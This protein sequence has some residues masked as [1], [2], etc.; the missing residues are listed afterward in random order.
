[1]KMRK[2]NTFLKWVC[3]G[4][5]W[6]L[7]VSVWAA[8]WKTETLNFLNF[9]R[10]APLEAAVTMGLDPEA[11]SNRW[12]VHAEV[13]RGLPP[14]VSNEALDQVAQTLLEAFVAGEEPGGDVSAE[15]T[16]ALGVPSVAE[17]FC[18]SL[19]WENFYS[20][21]EA[22]QILLK[23]IAKEA[24]LVEEPRFTGLLFPGYRRLG[25][26]VTVSPTEINGEQYYGYFFCFVLAAL[27][28][29]AAVIGRIQGPDNLYPVIWAIDFENDKNIV[30]SV[31]LFPD[32][33]FYLP[34]QRQ[35]GYLVPV[36]V[37]DEIPPF[38]LNFVYPAPL[39]LFPV[40]VPAP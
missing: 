32:G 23:E 34:W 39:I 14:F 7:P 8:D 35:G 5:L 3:W 15:V 31:F 28:E 27:E 40:H 6:L 11:V 12:Q 19:S 24:L 4:L 2:Q 13:L 9:L 17:S 26:A 30:S 16:R 38:E 10:T 33:S 25:L 20:L 22:A 37:G 29:P 18:A 1:M 36:F 21:E